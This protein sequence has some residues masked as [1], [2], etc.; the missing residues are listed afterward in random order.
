MT[1]CKARTK[2]GDRCSNHQKQ[3]SEFC[4]AHQ[5]KPKLRQYRKRYQQNEFFKKLCD[6]LLA[7]LK[8][9]NPLKPAGPPEFKPPSPF[10]KLAHKWNEEDIRRTFNILLVLL[11]PTRSKKFTDL[12][13]RAMY[14][15]E[16]IVERKI[17]TFRT[18]DGHGRFILCVIWH[19]LQ[20][21][22]GSA[23]LREL[24]FEIPDLDANVT[25]F[26]K[27]LFPNKKQ[28][29]FQTRNVFELPISEETFIYLNF[30]GI[31]GKGGVQSCR[32]FLTRNFEEGGSSVL[33][34]WSLQ[35]GGK[36]FKNCLNPEFKLQ[37]VVD[38]VRKDFL[39]TLVVKQSKSKTHVSPRAVSCPPKAKK[40][41]LQ[42]QSDET[43]RS[44]RRKPI[45]ERFDDKCPLSGK[46]RCRKTSFRPTGKPDYVWLC[47][48]GHPN[49]NT[50]T[51]R[52]QRKNHC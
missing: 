24:R 7:C 9:N 45:V 42:A 22:R 48:D 46:K 12:N 15:A 16:Q 27:W 33:V 37:K 10:A 32:E 51:K 52:C 14:C 30:C 31:G 47:C 40:Y 5:K 3:G 20:S 49:H 1:L 11:D 38:P 26:H 29:T 36:Q 8:Q 2:K 28:F 25:A 23:A 18:L 44:D 41:K 50:S 4:S 21:K 43:T 13:N 17:T 19:L 34:S 6:A 35:R 39:T